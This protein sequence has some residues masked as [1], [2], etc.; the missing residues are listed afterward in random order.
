MNVTVFGGSAPQ[1]EE[2]AYQD[3][4]RLG[5]LL[6]QA[7]HTVLTGGYM[8]T[9]EAVSRGAKEAG[10]HVIG[11]TCTEIE[12]WRNAKAN[13]WVIE[14]RSYPTLRERLYALI[15]DCDAAIAL[16][17]GIGT[18]AEIASM[19]SQMQTASSPTRPLV[20][21]GAG[22]KATIETMIQHLPTYVPEAHRP[23]LSYAAD[24]DEAAR[25]LES[26]LAA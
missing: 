17:G 13:P 16:P 12:S 4:Q 25:N 2:A 11:I 9:M 7:G 5:A 20:L 3:A 8:G 24:V 1:P 15:D 26:L 21:I 18:L 6:A 23:L 22:W 10:G 14:E 19:W